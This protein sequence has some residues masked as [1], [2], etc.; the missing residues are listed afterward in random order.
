[1]TGFALQS[2]TSC[3][4]LAGGSFADGGVL[5]TF[6]PV[7]ALI[8]LRILYALFFLYFRLK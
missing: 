3:V 4:L 2:D 7:G 1:M 6:S 5:A 8:A